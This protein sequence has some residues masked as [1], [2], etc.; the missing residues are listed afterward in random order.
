MKIREGGWTFVAK[1]GRCAVSGIGVD[2][3]ARDDAMAEKC[4]A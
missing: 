4:F 3:L 1:Y 2:E